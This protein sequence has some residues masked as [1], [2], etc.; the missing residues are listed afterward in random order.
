MPARPES[1]KCTKA[2]N[3]T[4]R[5]LDLIKPFTPL[6]PEVAAPE[7]KVPFNQKMM[8]TGVKSIQA[9]ALCD[10]LVADER[11]A[12][13]VD[14]PGHEPNAPLWHCFLGHLRSNILAAHDAGK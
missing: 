9:N 14:L 3:A 4:V 11:T 1:Q 6:L 7:S 8:W 12:Y 13:P 5:F 10:C 2:D